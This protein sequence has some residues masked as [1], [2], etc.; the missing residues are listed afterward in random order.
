MFVMLVFAFLAIAGLAID[1]GMANLTQQEMQVAVDTAAL[2]GLRLRDYDEYQNVSDTSRRPKVSHMVRLVFDDDLHPTGNPSVTDDPLDPPSNFDG[3][4]ALHMGAGSTL[5][6]AGDLGSQEII[7]DPSNPVVDDPVLRTN[8]KPGDE[9]NQNGDMVSGLD[10][11]DETHDEFPGYVR[12]DF[13]AGNLQDQQ[14]QSLAFL[15]RMRRTTG[16]NPLD[17]EP[18]VSSRSRPVPFLFGLGS[19]IHA[20]DNGGYDPRREGMTIRATAIAAARPALRASP[21]PRALDG[22]MIPN[23]STLN[24]LL[25]QNGQQPNPML[26]LY[27]F[28]VTLDFWLS[29][30]HPGATYQDQWVPTT[31]HNEYTLILADDQQGIVDQATGEIVGSFAEFGTCIGQPMEPRGVTALPPPEISGY[32]AIYDNIPGPNGL[33]PRII[34][35]GFCDAKNLG[36]SPKKILFA[37]GIRAQ[38]FSDTSSTKVWV[39]ANGVSARLDSAA[40][41]LTKSEWDAVIAKNHFLAYGPFEHNPSGEV[42]YDYTHIRWG[43]LLAA[44]LAR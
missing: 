41:T 22:A 44:T 29:T 12:P 17:K 32:V 39:A 37:S 14:S 2:E 34:G 18:L 19:L 42:S 21:P 35:Y 15:V 11:A 38:L 40:P 24:Q 5:Q 1:I 30:V 23:E 16:S 27:P 13:T 7:Y 36:G 33:V 4:D 9:N 28:A 3:P 26:G 20:A 8:I 10:R 6:V 43:T 31:W 25:I